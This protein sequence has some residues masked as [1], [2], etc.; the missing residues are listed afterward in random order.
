MSSFPNFTEKW[1]K[2]VKP[3]AELVIEECKTDPWV[4]QY[5]GAMIRGIDYDLEE[6]IMPIYRLFPCVRKL[7]NTFYYSDVHKLTSPDEVE[8]LKKLGRL[9]EELQKADRK[10]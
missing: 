1:D 2:E 3:F 4:A 10:R 6:E 9:L 5:V 7:N 8:K